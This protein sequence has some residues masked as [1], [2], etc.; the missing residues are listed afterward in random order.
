MS[1]ALVTVAEQGVEAEAAA[2]VRLAESYEEFRYLLDTL[3]I[4]FQPPGQRLWQG[5]REAFQG[6]ALPLK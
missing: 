3:A 6:R 2:R 1:R 4:S 5:I